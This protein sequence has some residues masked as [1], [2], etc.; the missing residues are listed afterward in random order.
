[1][2]MNIRTFRIESF[3]NAAETRGASSGAIL[4]GWAAHAA[5]V[6]QVW[7]E[8]RALAQLDQRGLRDLGLNRGDVERE[9]SRSILD[10]PDR[11]TRK[12]RAHR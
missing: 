10:V 12:Y 2:S 5:H 4:A 3:S 8:R 11:R 6:A 7:H 1:M 9:L